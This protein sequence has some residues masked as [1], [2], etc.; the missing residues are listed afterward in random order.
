MWTSYELL[1]RAPG[2]VA[3]YAS[4]SDR[5]ALAD[6]RRPSA[7]SGIVTNLDYEAN[8][9]SGPFLSTTITGEEIHILLAR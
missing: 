8:N 2:Q 7:L 3:Q 5:R 4:E 6:A 1:V 9:M